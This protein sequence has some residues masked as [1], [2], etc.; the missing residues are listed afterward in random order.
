VLGIVQKV[1]RREIVASSGIVLAALARA[2]QDAAVVAGRGLAGPHIEM[3]GVQ[4]YFAR[5]RDAPLVGTEVVSAGREAEHI[6]ETAKLTAR[7]EVEFALDV[8]VIGDAAAEIKTSGIGIG[9]GKLSESEDGQTR[10]R[11]LSCRS[12]FTRV[13]ALPSLHVQW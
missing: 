13:P 5:H 6:G 4:C 7:A 8:V 10:Q 3:I 2:I 9:H 11:A 1:E 12:G